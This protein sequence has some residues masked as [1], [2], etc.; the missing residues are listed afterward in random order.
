MWCEGE[1]KHTR[2]RVQHD[3]QSAPDSGQVPPSFSLSRLL[4]MLHGEGG[5]DVVAS[6]GNTGP[7]LGLWS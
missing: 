4:I 1:Y 5:V 3:S 2:F 6:T 7:I